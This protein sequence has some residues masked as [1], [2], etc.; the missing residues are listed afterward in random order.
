MQGI[1]IGAIGDFDLSDTGLSLNIGTNGM[2]R[3]NRKCTVRDWD[4]MYE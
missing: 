1:E 3:L 4:K 2:M